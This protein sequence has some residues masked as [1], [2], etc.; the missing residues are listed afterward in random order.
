MRTLEAA[1]SWQAD[2]STRLGIN[3]FRYRLT[4]LI[5][6]DSTLTYQNQGEQTGKGVELEAEWEPARQ[7]RVAANYAWQRSTDEQTGEDPGMS[8]RQHAHLRVDWQPSRGWQADAQ[9]NWVA[10]RQRQALDTRPAVPD[11]TTVDLGLRSELNRRWSVVFTARNLFDADVREPSPFGTP[12]VS[13]P[14]D[15]PQAGRAIFV[16]L[17]YRL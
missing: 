2:V 10:G 3:L 4:D 7:W 16:T 1:L 9:V 15:L 17:E 6:L 5:R 11:Y 8:P 14:H 12:F 13:I